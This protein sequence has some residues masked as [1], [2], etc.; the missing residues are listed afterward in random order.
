LGVWT[1]DRIE[2]N[3]FINE[4]RS[5]GALLGCGGYRIAVYITPITRRLL[6]YWKNPEGNTS[7]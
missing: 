1:Q 5:R 2:E 7:I 3:K 4:V 6:E